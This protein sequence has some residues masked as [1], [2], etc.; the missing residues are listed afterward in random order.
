MKEWKAGSAVGGMFLDGALLKLADEVIVM[1]SKD[2]ELDRQVRTH[3]AHINQVFENQKR[4]RENIKSLD[5]MAGSDLVKRYLKDLDVE[6]DDLKKTRTAIEIAEN[7]RLAQ[8]K[9][10]ENIL[11]KLK[12]EARMAV[13]ALE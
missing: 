1:R 4:L 8:S 3:K 11:F 2:A 10:L 13:E 9:D 7:A 12:N 6:E 5:K